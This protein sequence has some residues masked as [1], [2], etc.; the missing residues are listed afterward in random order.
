[1]MATTSSSEPSVWARGWAAPWLELNDERVFEVDPSIIPDRCFGGEQDSVVFDKA[2]Y[3]SAVVKEPK[4]LSAYILVYDRMP[5]PPGELLSADDDRERVDI[6]APPPST[7]SSAADDA[8]TSSASASASGS[9][10]LDLVSAEDSFVPLARQPSGFVDG[11]DD[12]VTADVA[13]GN[14]EDALA[15]G[16]GAV[17]TDGGRGLEGLEEIEGE[18][19]GG[20]DG[21]EEG[22]ND[23]DGSG[24]G[25]GGSRARRRQRISE[26]GG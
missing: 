19:T 6:G 1:M 24:R 5:P 18:A 7:A 9:A 3:T 8:A 14:D 15:A 11:D 20:S 10:V 16:G 13:G 2:R 17:V 26:H 4:R 23:S 12:S 21:G 25:R 22:A